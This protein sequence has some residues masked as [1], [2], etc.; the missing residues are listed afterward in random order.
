MLKKALSTRVVC[1]AILLLSLAGM[2]HEKEVR[3]SWGQHVLRR[4]IQ[5]LQKQIEQI[6]NAEPISPSRFRSQPLHHRFDP[7]DRFGETLEIDLVGRVGRQ[8]IMRITIRCGV[9]DH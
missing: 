3:D 7:F 1:L 9:G 2:W 6:E 5:T 4:Q 8:M